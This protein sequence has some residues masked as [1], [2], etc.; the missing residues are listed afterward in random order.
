M[1]NVGKSGESEESPCSRAKGDTLSS[2]RQGDWAVLYQAA[3][4]FKQLSPWQWMEDDD[5]FAVENPSDGELGYCAVMGSGA[6]EFGLA[7]FVGSEGLEGY[8]RIIMGEAEPQSFEAWAMFRSLSATFVDRDEL[9][10]Q[11]YEVIRSLGLRFRGRNAWPLLRSQR[12]GYVPWYLD[13]QEALFL[14]TGLQQACQVATEVRDKGLDLFRGADAGLI[15]GR[16]CDDGRWMEEWRRPRAAEREAGASEPPDE[17]RL[18]RLRKAAGKLD[19][20]WELDFFLL[21]TAVGSGSQRPYYPGCILAIKRRVGL[22]VGTELMGPCPSSTEK[23][24]AVV[25]VLQG[26]EQLPLE[27]RVARDEVR[28]IVEPVAQGLGISVRVV[29]LPMLEEARKGLFEHL[30]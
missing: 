11:D 29:P 17:R 6:Q 5:L 4:A 8:R 3:T 24:E 23:Q 21:P 1:W 18:H 9:Q 20:S 13:R 25:R 10:K 28:R 14:T 26:A 16:Y 15:L 19:G 27:I 2:P 22:I 30:L 7:V 12:P